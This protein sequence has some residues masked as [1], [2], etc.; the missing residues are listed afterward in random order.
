M[1]TKGKRGPGRPR[2]IWRTLTEKDCLEWKLNEVDPCDRGEWRSNER[3]A[4]CVL[5]R[6][7]VVNG[8]NMVTG[9]M[10]VG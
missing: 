10:I 5:I 4:R 7:H 8:T 3:S 9:S 2:I 6:A 1:Q